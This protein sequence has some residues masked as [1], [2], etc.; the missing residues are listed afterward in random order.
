[1]KI[2]LDPCTGKLIPIIGEKGASGTTG[3]NII[4]NVACDSTVT[5]GNIVRID[6]STYVNAL[7]DNIDNAK[8]VGI[9]VSKS[10]VNTCNVQITGFTDG[11]YAGLSTNTLYFLSDTIPG[12]LTTT[13]PTNP[14]SV[15]QLV[16][17]PLST[18]QLMLN[19]TTALIR[20]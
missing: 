6:G 17:K 3:D 8:I 15:V 7:A 12:G 2:G 4:E 11:I 14:D 9:C 10:D 1:M 19:I 13:P 18:S 5:V 20:S 16:G